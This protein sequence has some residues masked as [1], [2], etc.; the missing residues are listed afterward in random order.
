MFVHLIERV[1]VGMPLASIVRTVALA[2]IAC[3]RN[4]T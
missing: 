2:S 3:S 4:F 1:F